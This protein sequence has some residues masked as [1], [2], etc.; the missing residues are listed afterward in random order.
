MAKN[1]L[2]VESPAKAKTIEKYLGEGFVVKS[3]MGHIRDLAKKNDAID[4]ED[5]YKPNYVVP[6]EKKKVVAELKKIAKE[7]EAVW[8]ATDEDREG[9]A[10]SWHLCEVLGLDP[11]E[12]KRIVF[13]E[14]TKSA[15]QEAVKNPRTVNLNLVNAQQARRI[16]DRLVG[17]ELS[18]VL[19]RKIS[20]GSSLSAG[21]VQSVAVRLIVEREAEI[22][23]HD[24]KA[25]FRVL[26][27]FS[28]PDQNGV[29]REFKAECNKRFPD[30]EAA[31]KF[32]A[33]CGSAAYNVADVQ[34]KP[35]KRNPAAPFTTSTLQ[36]EASRKLSFSVSRTMAVAQKLYESGKIT[37]MRTD[38]VNLSDLAVN[39]AKSV[40]TDRYGADYSRPHQY[41]NKNSGAQEAH[42]AI[43]PTDLSVDQ[44]GND[45]AEER[46]YRLI[47]M[48]TIASQMSEAQFERT[49]VR[50]GITGREEQLVAKGEVLT[51]EGFLKVYQEDTDDE[52][53]EELDGLL[54]PLSVDQDLP[55]GRMEATER[56]SK[57]PARYTEASLVRKLEELGI[58]RPSTYA[59][60]ISTIQKREYV[61]KGDREGTERAYRVLLVEAG[62]QPAERSETEITGREKAKLFP[63]DMG[64]LVN[65]FLT[66]HF[67][68]VMDYGF[69]AR[70]EKQFDEIADGGIEWPT[71]IDAFYKPFHDNIEEVKETAERVTG[72]RL[73]GTHP[74]SGKNVYARMGRY[75]PMV[76]VGEVEDEEKPRFAKIVGDASLGTITLEQALDLLVLPR[77]LGEW[78]GD[79][80]VV[81]I[82]RFGPYVRNND[83]FASIPKDEDPMTIDEDRARQLIL[84]KEEADRKKFIKAFE[85]EDIQLLNGRWGPYI[86]QGKKN[87]KIPKEI[88]DPSKLTLEEVLK[89]IEEAPARKRGGRRKAK[90]A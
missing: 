81:G 15:I 65:Q 14:I 11:A 79:N 22:D 56:F 89:I 53:S 29:E 33:A 83:K 24:A 42:E 64:I 28:V 19:W 9:E 63:T 80:L 47:W 41:K 51:F 60:T 73:L 13:H 76:Q 77:D 3:S 39:T 62:G 31:R 25:D 18:P 82:G 50:I 72:Q 23:A 78:R 5:G 32:L 54:P 48:R 10:I 49:T 43:R 70:I 68:T 85:E 58:G 7:A 38:S 87:V 86:K 75:G 6:D 16:L 2:I 40:I 74:K 27:Y 12:T 34:V 84:D 35:G 4:V 66:E 57:P 59:P 52:P 26:A 30:V 44:A 21:R 69:T 17:F 71:M 36:Q 45:D 90:K 8:L 1:L 55:L 67:K 20:R 46:L 88:E 37:Y 61:I